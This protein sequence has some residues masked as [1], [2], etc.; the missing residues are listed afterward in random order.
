[1]KIVFATLTFIV[2]SIPIL[3]LSTYAFADVERIE[4]TSSPQFGKRPITPVYFPKNMSK[5]LPLIISL[6]GHA[7][8]GRIQDLY[9]EFKKEVFEKKFILAIPTGTKDV[10]GHRF[11]ND[12][13]LNLGFLWG[14]DDNDP[15]SPIDD[16]GFFNELIE[17]I[18]D[19][20]LVDFDNIYF[21]GH[22]NGGFMSYSYACSGKYRLNKVVVLAG[23]ITDKLKCDR[24]FSILHIHGTEDGIVQYNGRSGYFYSVEENLN[25]WK[26]LNQCTDAGQNIED[27]DL[28]LGIGNETSGMKWSQCQSG[29]TIELWTIDGGWHI[30]VI[31]SNFRKEVLKSLL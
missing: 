28:T 6:H 5:K 16:I 31:K 18:A 1:M 19:K 10:G 8:Q 12:S 29:K 13:I 30:P 14:H 21:I 27:L 3:R 7:A 22:S 9:F 15:S 25:F 26:T 24:Q 20:T 4:I 2:V 17:K 11:W 23:G